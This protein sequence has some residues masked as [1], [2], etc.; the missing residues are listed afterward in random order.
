MLKTAFGEQAMG[1]SQTLQWFSRF[2]AG[3]TSIDDDERSGRPVS[4]SMLEMTERVRQIICRDHRC[5][6]DE[7]SM[8]V[9]ISHGTCHKILTE[10][11]K[12]RHVAS[13]FIPRFLSVDQ[14]QQWLD[15]CLDHK[16][17]AAN[18]PSFLSNVI[19][20]DET[21]VYVY[22]PETK[23][24][25]S[26]WKSVG[27]PRPKKAK[28]VKSNIKSMLICFFDQKGIVHKEFVP[29]GQTVNA[30][31]YVEVLRH[32]PENARR[33][34][35][36][37]WQ[38]NTWLLHHDNAPAHAALLTRCFLTD[39]NMTVVPHPPYLPDLAPDFF[40]FSKLKVE[41]KGRRFRTVEEIQAESQAVLN[42]LWE[43]DFQ[44]CFKN[45]Q[46]HWDR[47]QASEGDYYE[48]DASP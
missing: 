38:N 27:S 47:F 39:N 1:R 6:I 13:K 44:E 25:S 45:W 23:T 46:R 18:D 15:V 8:L 42:T 24:Q 35:P 10:D 33:K 43:N 5:T 31:F 30:A 4:S 32:L 16:E 9:G 21:R 48:V 26:Q 11:L 17:N 12:M 22:D 7:V 34:W 36:D 37:Q 20:G 14:K 40:L 3:R 28:Q 19:M 29:P 41:L 2:K